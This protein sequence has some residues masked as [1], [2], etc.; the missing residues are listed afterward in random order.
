MNL[1]LHN[2][3]LPRIPDIQTS[4]ITQFPSSNNCVSSH[5]SFPNHFRLSSAYIIFSHT[6]IDPPSTFHS[7][8]QTFPTHSAH[9]PHQS[10]TLANMT[11]LIENLIS[12]MKD[13]VEDS[14]E[15]LKYLSN[16]DFFILD[17]SI[18]ESTVGQ[19][20]SHT[21]ENKKQI[22]KHVKACGIQNMIV[23]TFSHMQR[24]DDDF[25]IWLKETGEDF[26]KLFSFSEV[27]GGKIVDGVPDTETIPVA[28]AKNK[29]YGLYNVVF[30]LDLADPNVAWGPKWTVQ[31][32]CELIQQRMFW[33]YD[34]MNP[35]A[36]LILNLRDMLTAI[37]ATPERVLKIVKFLAEMPKD[38]RLFALV[39]EDPGGEVV[40]DEMA[41]YTRAV[42][43]VMDGCGWKDGKLLNHIHEKWELQTANTLECLAAGSTGVWASLCVEGAAMGHA[44]STVTLM[45]LVRMG[46]KKV[47]ETY[48]CK[49]FRKAAIA[50]TRLT[51]LKDPHPKQCVYGER[52]LDLVFDFGG[53]AAGGFDMADFFGEHQE[54]RMTT[55][56][57]PT[58]VVNRLTYLF[59]PDP[60]FTAEIAQ[61]MLG[62]MLTDL[63]S[64]RKEEYQSA[65]GLAVLFDRC[66][67]QLTEK[68]SDAIQKVKISDVHHQKFIEEIREM[69]NMWESEDK[70]KGDGML[71]FDSF[72]HGFLATYFGCYRCTDTKMALQALD[73]DNDG[74][75]DWEEFLVYI[76]WALAQYPETTDADKVVE[77]ALQK[78]L[79]PGMRD[80]KI[81]NPDIQSAPTPTKRD[82]RLAK[83]AERI[84]N[85][86]ARRKERA[87]RAKR[88]NKAQYA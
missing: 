26:S 79:I 65:M 55:L 60:Q 27:F 47:L 88:R 18:R 84:A 81:A 83:K 19:L 5:S 43:G 9:R 80:A 72:Y 7:I 69:W 68:M 28:L 66:G 50:V 13:D 40:P 3:L 51:T 62:Q 25:C 10:Q 59:G 56:A 61:K 82:I 8:R 35:N 78:G 36:R 6:S 52:A 87:S 22:Y 48:N 75:V 24:V 16:L 21:I 30:E 11:D 38:K 76:K 34:N 63:H 14:D 54:N 74:Y 39:F 4:Y 45:N 44:S 70:V 86:E 71:E 32:M 46:N 15:K 73:M 64:G 37:E 77:I 41:A 67:G 20:R 23:A 85:R 57:S 53:M 29:K 12:D 1:N 49:E 17:N 58:M 31:D 2:P 42:R 33:V